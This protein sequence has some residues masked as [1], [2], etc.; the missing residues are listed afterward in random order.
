MVCLRVGALA[1]ILASSLV[2]ASCGF[3][4]T[5]PLGSEDLGEETIIP[6]PDQNPCDASRD[7]PSPGA[8][9]PGNV[10]PRD[11]PI[12]PISCTAECS[13]L[14]L[15][16]CRRAPA[17]RAVF[18][19]DCPPGCKR[20]CRKIYIACSA[21]SGFPPR[22]GECEGFDF[23]DCAAR[24]NCAVLHSAIFEDN[25]CALAGTGG[26]KSC[27]SEDAAALGF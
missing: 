12:P 26:F 22:S 7:A 16:E 5:G 11:P 20:A 19:D 1:S 24:N 21:L 2:F 9:S 15:V 27:H 23:D 18:L 17:C 10:P 3:G 6:D 4:R 13:D 14:T 25:G 8:P